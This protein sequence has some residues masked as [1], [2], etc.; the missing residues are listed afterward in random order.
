M[1]TKHTKGYRL[2][3]SLMALLLP[4]SM[5][6]AQNSY[7]SQALKFAAAERWFDQ[8]DAASPLNFKETFAATDG[9]YY[10]K[11]LENVKYGVSLTPSDNQYYK[12][13]DEAGWVPLGD[14]KTLYKTMKGRPITAIG[15][16]SGP[17]YNTLKK[18]ALLANS[19][20]SPI[21]SILVNGRFNVS[22]QQAALIKSSYD[23]GYS[24]SMLNPTLDG[25]RRL[26]DTLGLPQQEG[27]GGWSTDKPLIYGVARNNRVISIGQ[28][29]T[30]AVGSQALQELVSDYLE[31]VRD[32]DKL[33]DSSPAR[34][35][36][37]PMSSGGQPDLTK[38]AS[39]QSFEKV[40]FYKGA[41][42]SITSMYWTVY[43]SINNTNYVIAE[44]NALLSPGS[45]YSVDKPSFTDGRVKYKNITS[46]YNFGFDLLGLNN[47][48]GASASQTSPKT[49]NNA[50]SI[51]SGITYSFDGEISTGGVKIGGG[52]SYSSETSF[53]ISDM[54]VDNLSGSQV[55]NTAWSF[56]V[57]T[58]AFYYDSDTPSFS[59]RK[60]SFATTG[61][62]EPHM[63]WM[64]K[65]NNPEIYRYILVLQKFKAEMMDSSIS[66]I[67]CTWGCES[68]EHHDLDQSVAYE[69]YLQ[70][71]VN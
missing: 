26:R 13:V 11:T 38:I 68:L 9:G 65:I 67:S 34:A 63:S 48:T 40:Y 43:S 47:T 16:N 41:V 37:S 30:L 4:L 7:A 29:S 59:K 32:T 23:L 10:Y 46:A 18:S 62:F 25:I 27:K 5:L 28:P 33:V 1:P 21:Q 2:R 56:G 6:L 55:N 51:S 20:V 35:A 69:V 53:P 60:P 61:T 66:S 54:S 8:I 52:V 57:Y 31:W 22:Q 58:D 15:Q 24:V 17:F 45:A 42:Y 64:W 19:N 44:V 70:Q 3:L 14:Y 71:K 49:E 50:T 39:A 36:L 12:N